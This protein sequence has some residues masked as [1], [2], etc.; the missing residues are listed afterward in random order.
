MIFKFFM[1]FVHNFIFFLY[2]NFF[3]RLL[4]KHFFYHFSIISNLHFIFSLILF[5]FFSQLLQHLFYI[6]PKKCEFFSCYLHRKFSI[7]LVFSLLINLSCRS[8]AENVYF[9]LPLDFEYFFNFLN[10]LILLFFK[11][12]TLWGHHEKNFTSDRVEIFRQSEMYAH[13]DEH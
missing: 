3:Y 1:I 10:A 13:G 11:Q 4:R 9:Y 6:A 12:S 8:T 5:L 2:F 7:S